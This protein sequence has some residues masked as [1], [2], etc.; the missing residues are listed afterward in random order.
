[1]E[2][3]SFE[4]SLKEL[5]TIVKELE[6]GNIDLDLAIEKYTAA[7]K[8]AKECDERLKSVTEQVSKIVAENGNLENFSIEAEDNQ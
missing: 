4:E 8:I 3:K 2:K 1:M 7:M 5:E 6:N